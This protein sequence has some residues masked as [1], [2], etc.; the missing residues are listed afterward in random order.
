MK[1]E[2]GETTLDSEKSTVI[3]KPKIKASKFLKREAEKL[4]K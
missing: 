4:I 1:I 2:K 3:N